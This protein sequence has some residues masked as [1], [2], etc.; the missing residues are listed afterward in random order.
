MKEAMRVMLY[1]IVA[2]AIVGSLFLFRGRE[3]METKNQPKIIALPEAKTNGEFP[4]VKAIKSRRS[5]RT[6]KNENLSLEQVSQLLWAAQ[7]ITS[8]D[9]LRS[10]PSAGA[11]Y[12]IEIYVVAGKVSQLDAGIYKYDCK[13]HKLSLIKEG[14]KRSEL[15]SA[16]LGQD[17][18]QNGAIDIVICGVYERTQVKYGS[19]AE[20]YVF[21][22]A[23]HVAQNIYLLGVSLKLGT[24]VVGAFDDESVK[25]IIEAQPNENP[26]YVMPVGKI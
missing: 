12:P 11:L 8:P 17:S 4:L 10:S 5:V 23:G 21:M 24:V 19:R 6:Y 25:K 3:T 26:L 22:E 20:R 2:I 9:E 7:G 18:V 13:S 15:S 14:D 1:F 16:S